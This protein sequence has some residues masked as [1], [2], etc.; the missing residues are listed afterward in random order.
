MTNNKRFNA[1]LNNCQNPQAVYGV[2]LM[3]AKAGDR[4]LDLIL[5]FARELM[6]EVTEHG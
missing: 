1:A 6:K 5:R 2:L 4:E 3:L